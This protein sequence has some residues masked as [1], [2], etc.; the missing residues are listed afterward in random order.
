MSGLNHHALGF[1][2]ESGAI[3]GH[4][5]FADR[6]TWKTIVARVVGHRLAGDICRQVSNLDSRSR[7]DGLRI[8]C[9][10]AAETGATPLREN[11]GRDS[12]RRRKKGDRRIPLLH[13]QF[14][15]KLV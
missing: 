12:E 5:V 9:D 4:F 1:L 10:Q 13:S 3:H 11:K 2:R 14:T 6:Q 15:S 8:V 7:Y